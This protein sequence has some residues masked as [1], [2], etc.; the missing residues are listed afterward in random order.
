MIV[1]STEARMISNVWMIGHCESSSSD[2]VGI[3]ESEGLARMIQPV[4]KKTPSIATNRRL[5]RFTVSSAIMVLSFSGGTDLLISN[6]QCFRTTPTTIKVCL[7]FAL[8]ILRQLKQ[9]PSQQVSGA[10]VPVRG[11]FRRLIRYINPWHRKPFAAR[12]AGQHD[13]ID[14]K[15]SVC[16]DLNYIRKETLRKIY[17][18]SEIPK[19]DDKRPLGYRQVARG[20]LVR[21]TKLGADLRGSRGALMA[22][23]I[24]PVRG[25]HSRKIP[26]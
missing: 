19:C 13:L 11:C 18:F 3:C 15:Y 20:P 10:F 12:P 6:I 4:M 8:I 16:L 26:L 17:L 9:T 14:R 1:A 5:P 23:K 22:N 25:R 21:T 24:P 7:E 2:S